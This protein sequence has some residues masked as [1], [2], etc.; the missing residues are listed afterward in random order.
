[1]KSY[2]KVFAMIAIITAFCAG[3]V[4]AN[5]KINSVTMDPAAP[6]YGQVVT[7]TIDY[8]A[9]LYSTAEITAAFSTHPAFIDATQ[10]FSGQVFVINNLGVN[11]TSTKPA[12]TEGG[13]I[14][15]LA[16]SPNG[17]MAVPPC[18]DCGSTAGQHYTVSYVV[19]VPGVEFF[20][21]F[22]A[23]TLYL[24][25]AMKYSSLTELDWTGLYANCGAYSSSG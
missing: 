23:S 20:Q 2:G 5:P 10:S 9:D 3:S 4:L 12:G 17:Y 6:D 13:S 22:T 1:M 24:H 16:N 8:C 14:G 19:N 25:V 18:T 21:P 15:W 11:V 7:I